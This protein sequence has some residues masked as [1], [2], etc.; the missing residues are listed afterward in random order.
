MTTQPREL[1]LRASAAERWQECYMSAVLENRMTKDTRP[2]SIYAAEGHVVHKR[3]A[4]IIT[5]LDEGK[6]DTL[7]A[8]PF[9]EAEAITPYIEQVERLLPLA[10][11]WGVEHRFG[12]NWGINMPTDEFV[13]VVSNVNVDFYAKVGDT[14]YILDYKHG[15]GERV[16]AKDN[17]QLLMYAIAAM[18]NFEGGIKDFNLG[19]VQP[20][21]GNYDAD[22]N[23]VDFW[24]VDKDFVFAE[25]QKL[26][27]QIQE[28]IIG[29]LADGKTPYEPGAYC[30]YCPA[31]QYCEA[32]KRILADLF[33]NGFM[34]NMDDAAVATLH[35][36]LIRTYL[37][38]CERI[39]KEAL[40]RG[41]TVP[42]LKL[43]EVAGRT[44]WSNEDSVVEAL[45]AGGHKK[46]IRITKKPPTITA[47]KKIKDDA[48]KDI[49]DT[50]T[51]RGEPSLQVVPQSDKRPA[52]GARDATQMF[53]GESDASSSDTKQE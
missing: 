38:E 2:A 15:A 26:V 40:M 48:V 8:T 49:V 42:K 7:L 9:D 44:K 43:V 13:G 21:Y 6:R 4:R 3:I 19:I 16:V 51:T 5:E 37:A 27:Q 52:A 50:M 1:R 30:R 22:E 18:L 25:Y 17:K 53:S 47:A 45:E 14:I 28:M 34:V 23:P 36:P 12:I 20:R 46:L 29:I 10:D 32:A 39:V 35:S 31:V 33:I 24:R 11:D 41:E